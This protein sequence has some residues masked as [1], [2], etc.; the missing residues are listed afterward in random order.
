MKTISKITVRRL[1]SAGVFISSVCGLCPRGQA[2]APP[3][4]VTWS[5]GQVE[6]GLRYGSDNLNLGFGVRGGGTLAQGFYIGGLFDYF[7]GSTQTENL[8]GTT[9]TA[10]ASLWDLGA[11]GGFDFGVNAKVVLRPF[12]GLGIAHAQGSVCMDAVGGPVCSNA[13]NDSAFFEL[14]GLV[15]YVSDTFIAGGD[16]RVMV[17]DSSAAIIAGHVGWLF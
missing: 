5:R 16:V 15:N 1:I 6:G 7:L 10:K 8:F 3:P 17:A 11:E 12:V 2:A 14:G 4:A 13:S 9:L